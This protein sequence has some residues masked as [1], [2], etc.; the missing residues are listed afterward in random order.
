[1]IPDGIGHLA[2]RGIPGRWGRTDAGTGRA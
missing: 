1:V 2:L